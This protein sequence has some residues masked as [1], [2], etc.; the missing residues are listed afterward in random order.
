MADAKLAATKA[1]SITSGV[2]FQQCINPLCGHTLDVG[3]VK[4]ACDR[5]G[6]LLDV[7]YDWSRINVPKRLSD[8]EHMWTQRHNPLRFSGV[9]RF[10]ELI[11]FVPADKVVTVG[12]GQTLLQQANKVGQYIGMNPGQLYLQYEG[13]NPSGSFKDNGMCAAFTHARLNR[14][15]ASRLRFDRQHLRIARYVLLRDQSDESGHLHRQRQDLL[16]QAF[17]SA[18]IRRA[19]RSN[20]RRLR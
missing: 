4:T 17:A 7:G 20:R 11:Q 9:W 3:Q 6:D 1:H 2:S 13:M 8:F 5:C 10:H 18:R 15:E 16:R 14:R 19:H 12:E